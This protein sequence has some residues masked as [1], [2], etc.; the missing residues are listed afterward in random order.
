MQ[1]QHKDWT[2]FLSLKPLMPF[3]LHVLNAL[4][5]V[6]YHLGIHVNF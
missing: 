3:A 1:A 4:M 5:P 6:V 2:L